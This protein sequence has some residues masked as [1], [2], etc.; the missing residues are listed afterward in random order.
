[1]LL[2]G[3]PQA[4]LLTIWDAGTGALQTT[5]EGYRDRVSSVAFSRDGKRL[6]LG[7]YDRTVRIWDVDIG[8]LQ[9]TLEGHTGVVSSVALSRDGKRLALGSYDE[10]VRIWDADIG[11]L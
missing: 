4:V 2:L 3:L 7:S 8:A 6:A 9:T 10:I 5:L 1:V 11:A